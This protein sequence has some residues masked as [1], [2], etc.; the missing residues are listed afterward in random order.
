M[1]ASEKVSKA[2]KGLV[3][4]CMEGMK[5]L[6]EK[7]GVQYIPYKHHL[8][9]RIAIIN[10]EVCLVLRDGGIKRFSLYEFDMSFHLS[11]LII[12]EDYFD[13]VPSKNIGFNY[14]MIMK[15]HEIYSLSREEYTISETESEIHI[16]VKNDEFVMDKK[17]AMW[18]WNG[19]EY[20][21]FT[22]LFTDWGRKTMC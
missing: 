14:E 22:L 8:I 5:S 4:Q 9:D 20:M 17:T 16:Q 21:T 18:Y 1:K 15:T 6:M 7:H 19:K 11:W 12:V 2:A 13:N 10:D 3:P